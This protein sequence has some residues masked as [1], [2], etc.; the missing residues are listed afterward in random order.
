M[1]QVTQLVNCRTGSRATWDSGLLLCP[2]PLLLPQPLGKGHFCRLLYRLANLCSDPWIWE[3]ISSQD[4]PFPPSTWENILSPRAEP[5]FLPGSIGLYTPQ[6]TSAWEQNILSCKSKGPGSH[7]E[8]LLVSV[9]SALLVVE[10]G[11][12]RCYTK[13]IPLYKKPPLS[14]VEFPSNAA[15]ISLLSSVLKTHPELG[16]WFGWWDASPARTRPYIGRK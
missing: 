6:P 8:L 1:P 12:N 5:T 13:E 10:K 2:F 11:Q 15:Y 14:C 3:V 4:S 9:A 16:M 7:T